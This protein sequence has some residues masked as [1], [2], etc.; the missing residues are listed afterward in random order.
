[1]K[2]IIYL[3]IISVSL[4]LVRRDYRC[5]DGYIAWFL[6]SLMLAFGLLWI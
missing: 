6:M 2:W 5:L 3:F 4:G 1:M